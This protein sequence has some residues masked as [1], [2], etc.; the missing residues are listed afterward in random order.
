MDNKERTELVEKIRRGVALAYRRLIEQ[1]KR[2][3]GEL[4]FS[5]N[6][7]IVRVKARDI[8]LEKE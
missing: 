4:I 5:Q 3:D 7:K 6:G 2:E 8:E 1:K